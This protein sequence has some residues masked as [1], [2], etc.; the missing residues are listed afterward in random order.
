MINERKTIPVLNKWVYDAG[1]GKENSDF[2]H[3]LLYFNTPSTTNNFSKLRFSAQKDFL[4]C[5]RSQT[6]FQGA[7]NIESVERWQDR[8]ISIDNN[9][10]WN[11]WPVFTLINLAADRLW[12]LW[13]KLEGF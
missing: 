6:R 4:P 3:L 13:F 9:T 11:A 1:K 5:L 10:Y 2:R 8:F 12:E 7:E